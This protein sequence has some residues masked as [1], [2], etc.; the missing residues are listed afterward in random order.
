MPVRRRSD[1]RPHRHI[2][3]WGI[4]TITR[5]AATATGIGADEPVVY[6]GDAVPGSQPSQAT[7]VSRLTRLIVLV[8]L[9]AA[10][11]RPTSIRLWR[12]AR[13]LA[14]GAGIEQVAN[15]LGLHSLDAAAAQLGHRWQQR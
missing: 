10:D 13:A 2:T 11:V 15:L 3:P 14:E 12:P 7:I 6:G 8:G 9:D 5:F 4:A 1:P